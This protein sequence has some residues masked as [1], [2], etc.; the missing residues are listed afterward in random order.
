MGSLAQHWR[1]R[2]SCIVQ[3]SFDNLPSTVVVHSL[4]VGGSHKFPNVLQ[5]FFP[6]KESFVRDYWVCCKSCCCVSSVFFC[7]KS[8][9]ARLLGSSASNRVGSVLIHAVVGASELA[10][11]TL[12]DGQVCVPMVPRL[13]SD[14]SFHAVLAADQCHSYQAAL[15]SAC[16]LT[17]ETS[18][19]V[20][21]GSGHEHAY[22]HFVRS[23]SDACKAALR[24]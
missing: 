5:I 20:I 8:K 7:Q 15:G 12:H 19:H 10:F 21:F 22:W 24:V 11:R 3:S 9:F 17:G 1:S 14:W 6:N 23:F 2:R 16:S 4:S 13:G 18:P